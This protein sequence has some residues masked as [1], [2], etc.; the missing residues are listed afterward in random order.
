MVREVTMRFDE[1]LSLARKIIPL[2]KLIRIKARLIIMS[3]LN[4]FLSEKIKMLTILA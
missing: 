1:P 2:N 3:I 4:M